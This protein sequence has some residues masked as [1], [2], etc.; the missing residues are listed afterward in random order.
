MGDSVGVQ[1][2][3][4]TNRKKRAGIKTPIPESRS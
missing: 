4:A 1:K 3:P 2:I